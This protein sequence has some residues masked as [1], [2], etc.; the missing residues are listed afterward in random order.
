[1]D[2]ARRIAERQRASTTSAFAFLAHCG[3][4]DAANASSARSKATTATG[5]V[6]W[7][8]RSIRIGR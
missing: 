4:I 2:H 7:Y 1:M 3:E 6:R 8:A 5:W